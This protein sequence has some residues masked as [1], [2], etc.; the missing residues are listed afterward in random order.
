VTAEHP[1]RAESGHPRPAAV[2]V[3]APGAGKSTVGRL[4]AAR[5]GVAVR[6]T[7]EDIERAAG[8]PVA[9]IFVEDG[10]PAF[11]ELERT[12]V[13]RALDEHPGLLILGGGAILDP[14]TRTL[15]AGHRV[16]YLQVGAAEAVRRVGLNRDRPLLLGNPRAQ[17]MRLLEERTPL[18][19][20]VAVTTIDTDGRT[21][22]QIADAVVACL[23]V[24][25]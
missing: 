4:V 23:R 13:Q 19:R 20:E 16:V 22:D 17:L 11:R 1:S 3:G 15:L 24:P 12:A 6:D 25:A 10:E 8:K 18:Y 21:P 9:D 14:G 2:L 7:D 5:L